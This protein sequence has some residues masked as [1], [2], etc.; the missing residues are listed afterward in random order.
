[1]QLHGERRENVNIITILTWKQIKKLHS[2]WEQ[3]LQATEV[4]ETAREKQSVQDALSPAQKPSFPQGSASHLI[5]F[6][7]QA[8][9][10]RK[11]ELIDFNS[12][13]SGELFSFHCGSIEIH[14]SLNHSV[15]GNTCITRPYHHNL[16][17]FHD[18]E[19]TGVLKGGSNL[20]YYSVQLPHFT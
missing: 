16:N 20:R 14:F 11:E 10:F 19:E 17:M 7:Y 4:N 2:W 8:I 9:S 1:M 12:K 15:V 13:K 3:L 5:H 6:Q 18:S